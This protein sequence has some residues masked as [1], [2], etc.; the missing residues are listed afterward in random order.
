LPDVYRRGDKRETMKPLNY[1]GRNKATT[2]AEKRVQPLRVNG[3]GKFRVSVSVSPAI[4]GA[5]WEK[6]PDATT[7]AQAVE[8]WLAELDTNHE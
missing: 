3:S 1:L 8:M 7:L 2:P 4:V 5:A 6:F